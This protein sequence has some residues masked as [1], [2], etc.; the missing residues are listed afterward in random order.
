[1]TLIACGG[2]IFA[3]IFKPKETERQ[4]LSK[5]LLYFINPCLV[6]NSFNI[7]FDLN[8]F[9]QFIFVFAIALFIHLLMI[10]VSSLVFN[11]KNKIL[12]SL[13]DDY[14]KINSLAS[15]FTNC[16]F[17]G[18]PLIR[19]VLGEEG[20]FF[21]MGY[22]VVFNISL[23]TFGLY[24]MSRTINLKRIIT[25]P[26]IVAV[27]A[28]F[29]LFCVPVKLPE[30]IGKPLS[31]IADLNTCLAMI[32]I[33]IL[34]ADFKI[35]KLSDDKN[36]T[37]FRIIKVLFVRLILISILNLILIVCFY[38]IFNGRIPFADGRT[39]FVMFMVVYICSLCPSA[40]SVPSMTCL[41]YKDTSY[42]SLIVCLT[43][44]FS[45]LSIP[46]F[47]IIAEKILTKLF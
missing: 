26:N 29:V 2:Y 14:N 5:M 25:N 27:L 6:L 13:E 3:K 41:F 4:F 18:I 15:V 10:F 20:V 32:L 9:K 23:W 17:I 36:K 40:T 19:G 7:D 8:K 33:G 34:F 37:I 35:Q 21:L 46:S 22:L 12:N 24:Q 11:S 39:L 28:G 30:F 47:V 45:L 38:K 43:S 16:G 1:M 42:A 44:L 31:M